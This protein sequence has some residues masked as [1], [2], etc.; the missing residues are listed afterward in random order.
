MTKFSQVRPFGKLPNLDN[1][2]LV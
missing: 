2:G 1:R